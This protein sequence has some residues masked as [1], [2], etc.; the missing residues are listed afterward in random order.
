MLVAAGM[1][2]QGREGSQTRPLNHAG[3][4]PSTISMIT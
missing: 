4:E 2:G 3:V 1:L